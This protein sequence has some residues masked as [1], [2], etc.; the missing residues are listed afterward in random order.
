MQRRNPFPRDQIEIF[1]PAGT[2]IFLMAAEKS[3]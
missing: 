3:D 1:E 2:N